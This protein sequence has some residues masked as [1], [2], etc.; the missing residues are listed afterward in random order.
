MISDQR[1]ERFVKEFATQWLDLEKFDV[2]EMDRKRFPKLTRDTRIQLRQQ[3]EE[4][5]KY[6]IRHNLPARNLIKAEFILAN[7]VTA[8]Y[9]NLGDRIETG[10]TFM[11]IRHEKKH[12][13]G[14]LSQTSILAGLSDGREPNAIKRGAWLARKIISE[15][16]ADPPPNVPGIEELDPTLPLRD[17]LALHRNHKGCSGCHAGIDRGE[18]QWNN[19]TL[20]ANS[21]PLTKTP[22]HGSLTH[23]GH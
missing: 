3:P 12:L 6:L 13:G 8:S 11:P 18:Y 9:H 20:V 21:T 14:L 22:A 19:L 23:G 2:V 1:F 15:P 17:R 5:L 10:F 4:L 16:P 7:E